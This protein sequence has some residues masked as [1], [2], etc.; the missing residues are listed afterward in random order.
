MRIQ[1]RRQDGDLFDVYDVDNTGQ[2]Q[3]S[4]ECKR[5]MMWAIVVLIL[6]FVGLF[7]RVKID[8]DFFNTGETA[9]DDF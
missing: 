3:L 2:F 9:K 4:P 7:I 5:Y 1:Q 6:V 8:R